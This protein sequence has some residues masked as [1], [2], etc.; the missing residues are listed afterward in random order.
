MINI[1]FYSPNIQY[2]FELEILK[3]HY[4]ISLSIVIKLFYYW[5]QSDLL[6]FELFLHWITYTVCMLYASPVNSL[7]EYKAITSLCQKSLLCF[8]RVE[9]LAPQPL[10]L[11]SD[12]CFSYIGCQRKLFNL[13][14]GKEEMVFQLGLC[15]SEC[16]S[17]SWNF[18]LAYQSHFLCQQLLCYTHRSAGMIIFIKFQ[19]FHIVNPIF[20]AYILLW[21]TEFSKLLKPSPHILYNTGM[22]MKTCVGSMMVISM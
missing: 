15:E 10:V 4:T 12:V 2:L 21:Q 8:Y 7:V 11:N 19:Y 17:L 1:L 13:L 18:N 22:G 14:L 5:F 16:N 20:L 3:Y 6:S 9:W